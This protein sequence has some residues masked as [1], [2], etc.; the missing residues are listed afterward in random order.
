MSM[1]IG[2]NKKGKGKKKGRMQ[3]EKKKR[4]IRDI[5]R[6]PGFE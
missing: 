3:G 6:L 5:K 1:V 4:S 2:K